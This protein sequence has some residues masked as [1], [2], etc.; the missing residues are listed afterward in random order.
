MSSSARSRLALAFGSLFLTLGA[1]EVSGRIAISEPVKRQDG[2]AQDDELG[3]ALPSGQAMNWRGQTAVIN[4]IGFRSPEPL[5]SATTKILTVGDSSVF[6]D[7]VQDNETLSSQISKMLGPDVDVQ[8]AGVPGYTCWQSRIWVQR[9]RNQFQPDILITYNQHSDY[10]RASGHDRVIAATQLGPIAKLGIGRII[11]Y[12]SLRIR[13][14]QGGSNL[15]VDEYGN[16][17][18][19]LAADQTSRGGKTVFVVPITDVD[20]ES[21]P[22]FGQAEPGDPGTR[23]EDY[24]AMMRTVAQNTGSVL[25]NGP[26]AVR[27]AGLTGNQALIDTVHPTA[28]G[29]SALANS[30]INAMQQNGLLGNTP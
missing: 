21:S 2:F 28:K 30:I 7:G 26:E 12:I 23:L 16:C 20:F 4:S 15:S 19:Q 6:G 9:I 3:W 18:T 13:M 14:S 11:S 29:H 24:R 1:L 27:S 5:S 10:R 17:L 22:L 25:V 8:N